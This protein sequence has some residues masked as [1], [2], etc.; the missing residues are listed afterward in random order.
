MHRML[1]RRGC[2]LL[3][4]ALAGCT[5]GE[6]TSRKAPLIEVLEGDGTERT[7]VDFGTVQVGQE[8][9]EKLRVRDGGT[10]ELTISKLATAA[11]F[12]TRTQLPVVIGVGEETLLEITYAPKVSDQRDTGTLVISSDSRDRSELTVDLAGQ[13]IQ[14]VALATPNPI[15]FK[16]VYVNETGRVSVTLSNAGSHPLEVKDVRFTASVPPSVSADLMPLKTTIAPGASA[17]VEISFSPT[18]MG[19]LAGELEIVLDPLQ[20]GTLKLPLRGRGVMALPKMCFRMEGS[21]MEQCTDPTAGVTS[22]QVRFPATCDSLL[23]PPDSGLPSACPEAETERRGQ[24]YFINEGNVPV[25]YSLEFKPFPYSGKDRCD[26]GTPPMVDFTFSN[27]PTQPDGGTPL[28]FTEGTVKLPAQPGDPRPWETLP[29]T[30]TYRARSRCREEATDLAQVLWVRQGEPISRAPSLLVLTADGTSKLP[31][32]VSSDWNCGS[33]GSGQG[34]PCKSAFYGA[35]NVGNAPLQITQV[36]LWEELPDGGLF[37]PCDAGSTGDCVAFAWDP[38]D[39]GDP[40]QYA[41][42]GLPAATSPSQPTQ[43]PIGVMVFA[44]NGL[45]PDGGC[46]NPGYACPNRLYRAYAKIHTD[47]PYDPVVIT[48]IQGVAAP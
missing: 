26:A 9:V 13:G 29:V 5:C 2:V 4:S 27:A 39:G 36:E 30:L 1:A 43:R 47:D 25:A 3:L 17:S 21:G 10:T 18:E 22:L 12:G 34:T 7:R 8:H 45:S 14:A 31:R 11:P 32:A 35:N 33:V 38:V 40:N 16:D 28:T 6:R 24:L 37:Q 23:F 19:E 42:H 20:G 15:D 48:R 46:F 44:P 41:P